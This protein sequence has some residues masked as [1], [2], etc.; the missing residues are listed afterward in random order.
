[1]NQILAVENDQKNNKKKKKNTTADIKNVITVF[2]VITI[3]FGIA[4]TGQGV[5]AIVN[6][7]KTDTSQEQVAEQNISIDSDTNTGKVI[8]SGTVPEGVQSIKYKWNDDEE[9]TIAKNG[10]T[11]INE[12]IDLPV[13]NNNL[14]VT[15]V[16]MKNS[17][18]PYTKEFTADATLPQL[19]L[20]L[21]DD[22]TKI[23]IVA[24]DTVALSYVTYQWD[25][26]DVQT[27]YPQEG[28][29][30]QLETEIE[31][32][33]GKHTLTVIAVNTNNKTTT[34]TQEVDGVDESTKPTVGAAIDSADRSKIIFS[35]S[36]ESGLKNLS[37][38]INGQKYEL[39]ASTEGQK[40]LQ[41]TFQ[42]KEGHYSI[43]V[44]AENIYG[45]TESQN[46]IYDY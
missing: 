20:S 17:S 34:K 21:S 4:I 12:E 19:A 7:F 30:A 6:S 2:C 10:E 40:E 25:D 27:I 28:S 36:D 22:G 46:F 41:Y 14:T 3:L 18:T 32:M 8:I 35:A 13:G 11:T 37:F 26:N 42:V 38:T 24:K 5:Y 29:E 31:A 44:E 33:T 1:L 15:I 45:Q 23:K 9:Q 16:D 39:P 43:T